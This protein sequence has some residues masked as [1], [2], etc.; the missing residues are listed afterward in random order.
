MSDFDA[1][2]HPR[3]TVDSYPI[4]LLKDT[5]Q[6]EDWRTATTSW[7]VANPH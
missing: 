1:N 5:R 7:A 2:S 3:R 4:S 6:H